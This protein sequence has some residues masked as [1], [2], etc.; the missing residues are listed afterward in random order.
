MRFQQL[1]GL[2]GRGYI[3]RIFR[4]KHAPNRQLLVNAEAVVFDRCNQ[5]DQALE[6]MRTLQRREWDEEIKSALQSCYDGSTIPLNELKDG[7][8][9][10]L[11]SQAEIN[12]QRCA[13]CMLNEPA[14]WDH[15]LPKTWFPEFSAYHANLVYVCFGCNNRKHD[16]F[17]DRDLIYCHPYYT[18]INDVAILHCVV[19]VIDDRLSIDYYCAAEGEHEEAGRIAQQHLTLL[20]L[21]ARFKSEA[22]SLVGGL[23]G[24]LRTSFPNGVSEHVLAVLLRAKYA[25]AQAHLGV[26][27]WDARLWHGLN[28]C[29]DFIVYLNNRIA[30]D[31]APSAA[32]FDEPAPRRP[33]DLVV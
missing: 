13:Y 14:T 17:N 24:E 15:Y 29:A 32:G 25:E 4:S 22:A 31:A 12:L 28:Q 21:G 10:E 20:G 16:D 3:G 30:N 11:R 18:V 33:M 8:L 27:A 6:G 7:I 26:N 1:P 2:D 9:E 5:Y 23:I 19:S